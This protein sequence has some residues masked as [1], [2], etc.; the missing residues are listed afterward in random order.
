MICGSYATW[1]VDDEVPPNMVQRVMRHDACPPRCS[2]LYVALSIT[3]GSA[4]HLLRPSRP[5][6]IQMMTTGLAYW[7]P[8]DELDVP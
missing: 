1:L 2:S 7:F 4:E 5:L 6:M 8:S 3:I